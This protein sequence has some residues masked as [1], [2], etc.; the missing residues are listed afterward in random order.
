MFNI[1]QTLIKK[2]AGRRPQLF[3]IFGIQPSY[4]Q[5]SISFHEYKL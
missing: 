3:K 5:Y 1:Y 4:F 2:V